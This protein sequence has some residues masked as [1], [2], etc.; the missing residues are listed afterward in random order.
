MGAPA[1][2]KVE[3]SGPGHRRTT[4]RRAL[5]LRAPALRNGFTPRADSSEYGTG[6]VLDR[7]IASGSK[8]TGASFVG[9]KDGTAIY[10]IPPN[11]TATVWVLSD[12][13]TF[14]MADPFSNTR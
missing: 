13:W 12:P 1:C 7:D 5:A 11:G 9:T 4:L 3:G 8:V 14:L 2:T 6:E 10:E